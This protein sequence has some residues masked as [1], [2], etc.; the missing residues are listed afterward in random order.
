MANLTQLAKVRVA[1]AL[2]SRPVGA[3]VSLLGPDYKVRGMQISADSPEIDRQ[4]KAALYFGLYESTELRLV[5]RHLRPTPL[6]VDLG[7]SLGVVT[8]QAARRLAPG[9]KVVCVEA[10]EHLLELAQ[11]NV[12]SNAPHIQAQFVHGALDYS[13]PPGSIVELE[14]GEHHTGSAIAGH[15]SLT[16]QSTRG[17]FQAP[18]M[19]LESV[20][21]TEQPF[22]LLADVEGAEAGMLLDSSQPLR[23]CTQLII[24]F[25]NA[26]NSGRKWS[27]SELLHVATSQGFVPTASHGSVHVLTRTPNH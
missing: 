8:A 27:P 2:C 25:H 6:L 12:K 26:V 16:R 20:I 3:V 5:E 10:N 23:N 24:E 1:R 9:S 13:Q 4:M 21:D 15:S 17:R 19:R 14:R 11:R 22:S 7:C 18:A